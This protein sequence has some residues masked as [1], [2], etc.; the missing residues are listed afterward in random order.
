MQYSRQPREE[1][2][3]TRKAGVLVAVL[4]GSS[5]NGISKFM[6]AAMSGRVALSSYS[7]NLP[8][9]DFHSQEFFICVF[10]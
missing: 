1:S 8:V 2:S 9:P 7:F 3:P 4:G 10:I 5:H 6:P